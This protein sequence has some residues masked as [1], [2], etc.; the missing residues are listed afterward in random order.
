MGALKMSHA[1]I[2]RFHDYTRKMDANVNHHI[3]QT[4]VECVRQSVFCSTKRLPALQVRPKRHP[5]PLSTVHRRRRR[6][7]SG[8]GMQ[9]IPNDGHRTQVHVEFVAARMHV[10]ASQHHV[11]PNTQNIGSHVSCVNRAGHGTVAHMHT[12]APAR[13]NSKSHVDAPTC[14][15]SQFS[16]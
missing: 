7:S 8:D 3:S 4:E 11:N 9:V 1:E 16:L 14:N 5:L 12:N 6:S 10:V 2:A 15:H 13:V